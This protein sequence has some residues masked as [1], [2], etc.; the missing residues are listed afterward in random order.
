MDVAMEDAAGVQVR[1]SGGDRVKQARQGS[2]LVRL[3]AA[4]ERGRFGVHA[5]APFHEQ[6]RSALQLA[7]PLEPRGDAPIQP[8]QHGG[9]AAERGAC[10]R[11][12][13]LQARWWPSSVQAR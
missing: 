6:V 12:Q 1:V 11:P 9:L 2:A 8:A 10:A 13:E 7:F 3:A 5:R 4:L